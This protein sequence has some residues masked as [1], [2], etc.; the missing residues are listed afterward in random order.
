MKVKEDVLGTLSLI[1]PTISVDVKQHLKKKKK[2]QTFTMKKE[3]G[4]K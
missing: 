4:R 2:I 1:V 3:T